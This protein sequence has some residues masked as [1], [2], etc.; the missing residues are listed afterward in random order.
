MKRSHLFVWTVMFTQ[1]FSCGQRSP[2]DVLTAAD[3]AVK[4]NDVETLSSLLETAKGMSDTEKSMAA[5]L[6]ILSADYADFSK[7]FEAELKAN[8]KHATY[9]H[10]S[11]LGFLSRMPSFSAMV[12][13]GQF[14]AEKSSYDVPMEGRTLE[15]PFINVGEEYKFWYPFLKVDESSSITL[16]MYEDYKNIMSNTSLTDKSAEL[17]ALA[18]K[19]IP[20]TK[21]QFSDQKLTGTIDGVPFSMASGKIAYKDLFGEKV[22]AISISSEPKP[23]NCTITYGGNKVIFN[24]KTLGSVDLGQSGQNITLYRSEG[25]KNVMVVDGKIMLEMDEEAGVAKGKIVAKKDDDNSINGYFELE[26]CGAF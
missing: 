14:N 11:A 15:M 16:S 3:K 21:L 26:M 13:K 6:I 23:D 7:E 5:Q 12:E 4:A 22:Y 8:R 19:Y 24:L 1:L 25:S 17:D 9:K 20:A 2:K 10:M 18:L